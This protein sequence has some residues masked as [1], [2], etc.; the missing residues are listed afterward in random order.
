MPFVVLSLML[1][2]FGVTTGEFVIAGILPEVAQDLAVSIPTAGLLVSAYAMGMIVGGPVLTA[3]TA[4]FARKQLIVVLLTVVV[5]GNLASAL[6]PTYAVL[7]A[8]RIVT[9]LVTSTFFAY[10]IVIAT[11]TAEP[12]KQASTVSK[13]AFGMNLS[14]ILGAPIGTFIGTSFGWRYTFV[15]IAACCALGLA[16]VLRSVPG[17]P[18]AEPGTSALAELRVF[19]RRDV[20]LAIAVTAIGNIG[21]LTVFTYFAP[22]LTSVSG[23]APDAVAVL[24]LVYGCGATVGNFVGGWLSDRAPMRSQVGLLAVLAAAF[25]LFWLVSAGTVST[26]ALV[27]A[28]GALGFAVIPGMQARILTTAA[29]APTLA[30]AVNASAYQLA[31][32]LAAWLGGRVIDAGFGTAS[33][34]LVSAA[35]TVAGIG[36]SCYAWTRD[37][38]VVEAARGPLS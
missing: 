14:M 20:R 9:S 29:S 33:I 38:R 6:A 27:F 31:A 13:L 15:A 23:F 5:V 1:C 28:V 8:A 11:A 3:L 10:A 35:V 16:M 34:Y 30:I 22:L 37:G 19:Q 26:V 25:V 17:G 4:R 7:F 24:L 21:L 12:G 18:R 32:A 36:V 2:V